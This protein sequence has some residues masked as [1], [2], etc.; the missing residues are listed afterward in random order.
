MVAKRMFILW[1]HPLFYDSLRLLLQDPQLI[2]VG[3]G[4]ADHTSLEEIVSSAPD[5][6]IVEQPDGDDLQGTEELPPLGIGA[7]VVYLSLADNE[8][9]VVQRRRLMLTS[10]EEFRSLLLDEPHAGTAGDRRE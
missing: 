5:V 2:L 8:L 4:P 3:A 1:R 7:K 6:V 10:V 9:N